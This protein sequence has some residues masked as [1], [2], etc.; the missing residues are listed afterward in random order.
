M[1]PDQL[2]K[3]VYNQSDVGHSQLF[4]QEARKIKQM[5]FVVIA[6]K[7][8]ESNFENKT[9]FLMCVTLKEFAVIW[10]LKLHFI[11]VS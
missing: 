7:V 11:D 5:T 4:V 1:N 6:L 3:R 10:H 8:Y 2:Q 9:Q